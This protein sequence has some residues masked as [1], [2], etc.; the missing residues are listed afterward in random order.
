MSPTLSPT[1]EKIDP[2][3]H[4]VPRNMEE[5][6]WLLI[7]FSSLTPSIRRPYDEDPHLLG[8]TARPRFVP[9]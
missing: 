6:L 1:K 7:I 9:M 5:G 8:I 2:I 3:F 4:S